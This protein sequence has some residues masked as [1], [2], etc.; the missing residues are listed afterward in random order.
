MRELYLAVKKQVP[1]PVAVLTAAAEAYL[2]RQLEFQGNRVA[3]AAAEMPA[4]EAA[5]LSRLRLD[6]YPLLS[7]VLIREW[8]AE[9]DRELSVQGY[10][11]V[12]AGRRFWTLRFYRDLRRCRSQLHPAVAAFLSGR[13]TELLAALDPRL[14]QIRLFPDTAGP[15][16]HAAALQEAADRCWWA[17]DDLL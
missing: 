8:A 9:L 11:R 3:V 15:G 10:R 17:G 12:L 4:A 14:A 13:D 6:R 5:V 1:L 2:N 16:R 7:E